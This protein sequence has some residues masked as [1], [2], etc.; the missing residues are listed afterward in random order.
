MI[1]NKPINMKHRNFTVQ[2]VNRP[3]LHKKLAFNPI[4]AGGS[5]SMYRLGGASHAPPP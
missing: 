1:L 5:E 3:I 4:K 2:T